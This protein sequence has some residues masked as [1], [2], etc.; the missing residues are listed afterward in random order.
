MKFSKEVIVNRTFEVTSEDFV[1]YHLREIRSFPKSNGEIEYDLYVQDGVNSSFI[2]S[3]LTLTGIGEI[4]K[5]FD[6]YASTEEEKIAHANACAEL[7]KV[8]DK[9]FEKS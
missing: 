2:T 6:K 1:K 4:Y 5:H 7:V 3:V 9:K 8:L